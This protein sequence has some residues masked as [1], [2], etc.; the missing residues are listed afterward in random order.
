MA[1]I[2][3]GT[4]NEGVLYET[5]A[6]GNKDN[7]FISK[8]FKDSVNPFETRYDRRPGFVNELRRNVPLNASDFGRSCEFEFEM[9]GDIFQEVALIIDLPS[10]LPPVEAALNTDW[11]YLIRTPAGTSYGY[12]R[13]IGYFLFSNI[14]IFQDKILLQEFSGDAL[15][16]SQLSRG[17]LNSAWLDQTLTGMKG[18]DQ[19]TTDLSRLATPGRLRLTIPM[20]ANDKGVPSSSM[21]QQR[22]RLKVTLRSLEDLVECSDNSI[23]K[24]APWNQPAFQVTNRSD[25]TKN[26]SVVPLP[27]EKIGKPSI[28]LE[29]RHTY[30]DPESREAMQEAEHEIPYSILYETNYTFTG[31][32]DINIS[33]NIDAEHPASRAFWFFRTR[34]NLQRNRYYATSSNTTNPYYSTVKFNIAGKQREAAAGPIVWNTLVPFC[35]EERDIGFQ[36]GEMNWDLGAW[37]GREFPWKRV[38]E[39]SINFSTAEKPAFLYLMRSP[40]T[41]DVFTTKTLELTIVVESWTLYIVEGER[42]YTAFSN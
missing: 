13:G 22:F 23:I 11:N 26:Y 25:P 36:V 37:A 7:Y 35:K 9:A 3:A 29:T 31:A 33:V 40:D 4:L 41:G 39:G 19:N 1:S 20:V 28:T 14:Q 6:R 10:W 38:P 30:L 12:T 27:R 2:R 5:V 32:A 17:S 24:P 16:A 8:T 34:D 42:G 21:R 18:F 15:W